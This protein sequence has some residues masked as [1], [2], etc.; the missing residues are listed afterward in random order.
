M[1]HRHWREHAI[2]SLDEPFDL[3]VIGGG[4][5]GCGV[6]FDAAQRGLRVLLVE[7][8][9]L[10]T[11]TS[12][13]SSKLIHGGLRY[14]KQMQFGVTRESCHE[15]DRQMALNPHL[16]QPLPFVFPAYRG[17]KTPG[18]MVEV[19]LWMYDRL[20]VEG[21]RHRRLPRE[22]IDQW[23]PQL[24]REELD[25]ALLYYDAMADDARLTVAVAATGFHYGGLILT[26][27]HV[28]APIRD[29]SGRLAGMEVCDQLSGEVHSVKASLVV[30]AT[31]AWVDGIRALAGYDD[32]TVRPSRGS[33][34]IFDRASLPLDAA[35]TIPSVDDGRPVF[36][37][38]HAEG[39][40]VGTT[41]LFHDGDINDPRPTQAEVDYL[42]R[43]T[44]AAFP[45]SPPRADDVLGA[46]AGVRPVIASDV[47]D[48]SE[49]SREERIW[50]EN[51][52]LSVAGG[53]L[54]TWRA[55][56][57]QVVDDALKHLPSE[58]TH[59][60]GDCMT[61][62]TALAGLAPPD[63]GR[64]LR[65]IYNVDGDVAD[66]MA[67][68]LAAL[69]PVACELSTPAERWPMRDDTDLC[70]AEVRAW[71]RFGGVVHL[72]DL[73]L[74]R[75]RLGM[76]RPA[77]AAALAERVATLGCEELG[78]SATRRDEELERFARD[79]EAWS[80]EGVEAGGEVPVTERA[81]GAPGPPGAAGA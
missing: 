14:L 63:L 18:W 42:L 31:G 58:R 34:L 20:T 41:D 4:I 55:T 75:A 39:A 77:Q 74:R 1:F 26:R 3:L 19:G 44:A 46:F 53:K 5:T 29:A 49:A 56:A 23:A 25:R 38:P 17:D 73:L 80:P 60:L 47:D 27:A 50:H 33:H 61:D 51:G 76:W 69:G 48:P 67:R 40:L 24:P 59:R 71:F 62:G 12:S 68:R 66:G 10:A 21:Y 7:K 28:E 54:T 72:S 22:E 65:T 79:A 35:L 45:D 81:D 15:R 6:F 78:W 16:V 36:F 30:N 9:D 52:L 32:R 64:R 13:R 37:I 11:G 2:A 70:V 8:D 57:E 43:T